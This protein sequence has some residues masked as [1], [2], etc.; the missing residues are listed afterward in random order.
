MTL[1]HPHPLRCT[2][3]RHPHRGSPRSVRYALDLT[4][5]AHSS[6]KRTETG[7]YGYRKIVSEPA[8]RSVNNDHLESRQAVTLSGYS[9]G[10]RLQHKRSAL[11]NGHHDLSRPNCVRVGEKPESLRGHTFPGTI[12]KMPPPDQE[13]QKRPDFG[14]NQRISDGREM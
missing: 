7:L 10:P 6:R 14:Y 8:W 5:C 1:S 13:P 3:P 12:I 11:V 9:H 2:T 4:L